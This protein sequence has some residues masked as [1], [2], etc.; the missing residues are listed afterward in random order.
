MIVKLLIKL[1]KE[2][3]FTYFGN[4]EFR[5][6]Y[7]V[8]YAHC[9]AFTIH[10]VKHEKYFFETYAVPIEIIGNNSQHKFD[11]IHWTNQI[12]RYDCVAFLLNGIMLIFISDWH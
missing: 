8:I 3:K 9:K 7:C 6:A 2:H 5:T 12:F 1:T 4:E 10:I 11:S